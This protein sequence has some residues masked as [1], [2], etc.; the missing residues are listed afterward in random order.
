[1]RVAVG[2][3]VGL[4]GFGAVT[5]LNASL[6]L[7]E[8][9]QKASGA[10]TAYTVESEEYVGLVGQPAHLSARYTFAVRGDGAMA[11]VVKK[12][13]RAGRV[14]ELDRSLRLPD[15]VHAEV[16]DH[17]KLVTATRAPGVSGPP[18]A[19]SELRSSDL[20]C[21]ANVGA[22]DQR[23]AGERGEP[24]LD[25]ATLRFIEDNATMRLTRW[26]APELGCAELRQLAEFKDAA[27][28][29]T[30]TSERRAV[31]AVAGQPAADLFSWPESYENVAPSER[32]VRAM[33]HCK[34]ELNADTLAALK[35]Q[36]GWFQQNRLK[37]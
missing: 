16:S 24:M 26:F 20:G 19:D 30:D 1:M 8:P 18:R 5:E 35:R 37:R 32:Y 2:L 9:A 22:P 27:G 6:E 36:D 13:D 29:V 21:Q 17:L 28:K 11:T 33:A 4:A 14:K 10:R 31:R 15:G 34:C 25:F 3:L 7:A 12:Y 23:S